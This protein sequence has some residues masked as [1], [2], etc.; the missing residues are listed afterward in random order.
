V[1]SRYFEEKDGTWTISDAVKK[2]VDFIH[3]NLMDRSRAALL[4]A[5]D[6]IL[7]RN[8]MI[9]FDPDTKREVIHDLREQA[10]AGRAPPARALGVA[11]QRVERSR[12]AP[13]KSDLVYRKPIPGMLR[14]DPW[15]TARCARSATWSDR[16]ERADPRARDRRLGVQPPG[17]RAH[18]PGIAA[19]RGGGRGARRRG[20]AAQD[21]RAPA[22][23]ITVDLEMP[24]MDGFTFL[25]IV[26][27]KRPT[28]VIVISGRNG[29]DDVFKALE[30]GAVDFIA[31]PTPHATPMLSSI[32]QELL[33]KVHA[34]RELRIEKVQE[35]IRALP[36]LL[37]RHEVGP[38]RAW[39]RSARRPADPRADAGFRRVH[40]PAAVR[41]PD[42]AAHAEGFTSGFAE[43]LDRLTALH[44]SE[45][46]GGE[47]PEP[48]TILL[49]P[50]GRHLE[51]ESVGGQPVT[52]ICANHGDRYTPSVDRLFETAAKAYGSELVGVVLTG[53]GDD[54]RLGAQAIRASGGR[55]IAESRRRR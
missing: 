28:P 47:R 4:G 35:R 29:E 48:G 21:A 12:A 16:D 13:L 49:A 10:P 7:C 15:H 32:A 40:E 54:G 24:K 55:V 6:V 53:M 9:Y 14:P 43:R 46:R 31:K 3:L 42:R 20:G 51:I 27:A 33:R 26:M 50:G 30:L 41:V 5:M 1:R 34:I 25:R 36:P 44:A 45:A 52:R 39:S 38:R 8:V 19:G 22:D 37:A 17:D 23:L 2:C 11:D 18:A